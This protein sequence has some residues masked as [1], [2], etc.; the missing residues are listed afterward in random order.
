MNRICQFKKP[1][2]CIKRI[3]KLP[4][5]L[6]Y[7]YPYNIADIEGF[8][9]FSMFK[10]NNPKFCCRMLT[11][12]EYID[13]DGIEGVKSLYIN[14]LFSNP[15][16]NGLGSKMFNFAKIHSKQMNCNGNIH[17]EACGFLDIYNL[18]HIFYRKQ[19]MNTESKSI[20]KK[21]DKFIRKNKN[22]T[23][24]DFDNATM[25]YPPVIEQKTNFEMFI[26]KVKNN[27]KSLPFLKFSIK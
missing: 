17:L 4:E 22:A 20:N 12:P 18:P 14:Y 25:Y 3:K 16:R 9:S 15:P 8:H 2:I 6:I 11:L 24:L 21:L 13:R 5:E 27:I 10:T 23:Y 19:G 7:K 1:L 26:E